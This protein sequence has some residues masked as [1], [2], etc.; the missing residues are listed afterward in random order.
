MLAKDLNE[1]HIG[2]VY[3]LYDGVIILQDFILGDKQVLLQTDKGSLVV[4]LDTE[5]TPIA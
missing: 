5:I 2:G 4:G 3:K 1:N